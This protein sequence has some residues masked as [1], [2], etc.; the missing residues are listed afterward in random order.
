MG[1]HRGR[2]GMQAVVQR[3]GIRA[4]QPALKLS[5]PI[6]DVGDPHLAVNLALG[7]PAHRIDIGASHNLVHLRTQ[8]AL[9]HR[10]SAHHIDRHLG[11]HRRQHIGV[12][13]KSVRCR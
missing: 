11:I 6:A 8:P 3:V 9:G 4:E 2:P 1:A 13:I 7:A 5:Q 12:T 10:R